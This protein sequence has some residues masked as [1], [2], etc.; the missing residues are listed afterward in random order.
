MVQ[1][2]FVDLPQQAEEI[3]GTVRIIIA[4]V[5]APGTEMSVAGIAAATGLTAETVR[6]VMGSD[7][8]RTVMQGE[9]TA[10]L[11]H[12]LVRGLRRMDLIVNG[13]K[14]GDANRINAFRAIVATYG[15]VQQAKAKEP[16]EGDV[17]KFLEH[18]GK[19]TVEK[20]E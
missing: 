16:T 20:T 18:F 15:V 6:A 1:P 9:A 11:Q 4:A 2:Q 14:V 10:L 12:A 19:K 7:T 17:E 8:Y 3:L 13:D 5:A